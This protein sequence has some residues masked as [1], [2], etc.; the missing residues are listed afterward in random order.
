M[1]KSTS[2]WGGMCCI[3]ERDKAACLS[4]F[5]PMCD[6]MTPEKCDI[7]SDDRTDAT[8]KLR[9][10]MI[11]KSGRKFIATRTFGK[12][13]SIKLSPLKTVLSFPGDADLELS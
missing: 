1:K 9:A 5:S 10:V 11:D 4:W 6:D 7:L 2:S 3:T 8:K 13:Y 12:R